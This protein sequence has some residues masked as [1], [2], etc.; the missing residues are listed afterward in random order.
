VAKV[1]VTPTAVK[2]LSVVVTG[3]VRIPYGTNKSGKESPT[4]M[5][6]G[7]IGNSRE[8]RVVLQNVLCDAI[9]KKL[10]SANVRISSITFE[11]CDNVAN[12][13]EDLEFEVL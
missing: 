6:K 9:G 7:T 13:D 8:F 10:S 1:M 5:F 12:A 2:S 4:S 3:A 11:G